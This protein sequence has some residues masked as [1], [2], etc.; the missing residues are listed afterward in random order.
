MEKKKPNR[1]LQILLLL[2]IV[3]IVSFCFS[4]IS[5]TIMANLLGV[6]YTLIF[7]KL[8]LFS[9]SDFSNSFFNCSIAEGMNLYAN[10]SVPNYN[11]YLLIYS[12]VIIVVLSFSIS[13]AINEL[14]MFCFVYF[15]K[16]KKI[17]IFFF[18]LLRVVI[19]KNLRRHTYC[20]FKMFI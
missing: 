8:I 10:S 13:S 15:S 3:F 20:N 11:K 16:L 9:F 14:I 4:C 18:N 1:F 12:S 7:E 17:F 19:K 6:A 5:S 2:F